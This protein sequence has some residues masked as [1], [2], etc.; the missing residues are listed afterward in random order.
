M[1]FNGVFNGTDTFQKMGDGE[2]DDGT[3]TFREKVFE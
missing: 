3:D 1:A 2:M